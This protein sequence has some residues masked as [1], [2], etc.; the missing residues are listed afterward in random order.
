MNIKFNCN[1]PCLDF[2]SFIK[3]ES[4]ILKSRKYYEE[5]KNRLA[6]LMFENGININ[7]D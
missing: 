7:D 1:Q 2:F 4:D 6:Q 3:D 5:N